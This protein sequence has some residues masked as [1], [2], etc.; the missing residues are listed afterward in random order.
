V[1]R[2]HSVSGP[3]GRSI[4]VAE[5]GDPGG[6]PVLF[7]HGTPGGGEPLAPSFVEAATARGVRLLGYDRPGY[8]GSSPQPGRRV[9]DAAADVAAIA[10]A[11]NID[12]LATWGESG[13][14]PHA[15]ACAARLSDVVTAAAALG[16][17][18]PFDAEG[19]DWFAG[20]AE[21]NVTEHE[22]AVEGEDALRRLLAPARDGMLGVTGAELVSALGSL[23]SEAD[24]AVLTD[25]AAEEILTRVRHGLGPAADGWVEDDLAFVQGWG[26]DLGDI[27]VPALLWHG[28]HDNFIPPTHGKWLAERI[29]GVEP[30]ISDADGHLTLTIRRVPEVL[31]WLLEHR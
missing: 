27:E 19:L 25:E 3:G 5:A 20:Q 17:P 29:P 31:D 7:H 12:R 16:S 6:F 10:A 23:V 14:A 11:L 4:H 8:G 21:E 18:A 22:T 15:L 30:R 13:G 26:F 9:V 24:A 1:P 2:T 28:Q